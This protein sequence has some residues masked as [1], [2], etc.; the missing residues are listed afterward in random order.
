LKRN[1]SIATQLTPGYGS[2]LEADDREFFRR[3]LRSRCGIHIPE[4]KSS[5]IESRLRKRVIA[6][7]LE[8]FSEYRALLTAHGSKSEEW[9]WVVASLTTHTTQ[10][11]REIDHF[12]EIKATFL[13][14]WM[15]QHP[16]RTL[17]VW[18]AACSSGEEPYSLALLL[19]AFHHRSGLEYEITATDID[20]QVLETASEGFYPA[21]GLERI[22]EEYHANALARGIGK[23]EGW[24]KVRSH[25]RDRIDFSP[26]NLA[27]TPYP[28]EKRFDLILCRNVLI[29]FPPEVISQVAHGL[30]RSS[31]PGGILFTGHSE[32]FSNLSVPWKFVKPTQYKR[33]EDAE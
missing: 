12:H 4:S 23:A 21:D 9:Q 6:L 3:E 1:A 11:F 15:K 5:L 13:P 7:G 20:T 32:S 17:R 14:Q 25:I 24:M 31:V 30:Y 27:K 16:K 28:F 26:L 19:N 10:W 29:Y 22:P 18:S 2:K 8:S 33:P